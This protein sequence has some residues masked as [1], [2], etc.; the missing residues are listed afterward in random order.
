MSS[1]VIY[2]ENILKDIPNQALLQSYTKIYTLR[3]FSEKN[4]EWN[5]IINTFRKDRLDIWGR[6]LNSNIVLY[7]T[8]LFY[9]HY[10]HCFITI[11]ISKTHTKIRF[12]PFYF[13][14]A[15]VFI[16]KFIPTS[17]QVRL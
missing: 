2:Q 17:K 1:N 7:F 11:S 16:F 3:N 5:I 9:F 13:V 14:F 4:V 6:T 12:V 15:I 10:F 8:F